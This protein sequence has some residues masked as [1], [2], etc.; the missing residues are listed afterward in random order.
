VSNPNLSFP[1]SIFPVGL[2]SLCGG[3]LQSSFPSIISYSTFGRRW[4]T[5]RRRQTW[6]RRQLQLDFSAS[7][8]N[9]SAAP[10]SVEN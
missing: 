8:I 9:L 7:D 10:R 6:W 3:F 1:I 2:L 4:K 5:W